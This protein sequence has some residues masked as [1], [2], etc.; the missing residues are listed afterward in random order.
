MISYFL[1]QSGH[2]KIKSREKMGWGFLII[3]QRMIKD[4]LPPDWRVILEAQL[5]ATL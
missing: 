5:H 2:A 4:Q 1:S 3:W